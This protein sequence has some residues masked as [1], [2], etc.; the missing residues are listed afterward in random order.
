ME[1]DSRIT[2]DKSFI[3]ELKDI[4]MSIIFLLFLEIR[5][6]SSAFGIRG[7]SREERVFFSLSYG[8]MVEFRPRS[9]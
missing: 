2:K 5:S 6:K 8:W 9:N 7:S 4:A 1:E 3:I